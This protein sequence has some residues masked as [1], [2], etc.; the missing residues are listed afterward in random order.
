M[1][2]R[3][4]VPGGETASPAFPPGQTPYVLED[5]VGHLLRRAHQRHTALFAALFAAF[6]LTP[7]Q[8]AALAFLAAAGPMTQNLLGR[9]TAMDPATIQGVVRRL[10]GRGLVIRTSDPRDRRHVKLAL[11]QAGTAC[12]EAA[13][14]S[15][16]A[17]SEATLAPLDPEARA[18][19]LALLRRIA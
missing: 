5:Q 17:V 7:T 4:G 10:T 19:F 2:I 6:G 9:S 16:A 1:L 14:A 11:T 15:A 12:Y 18:A 3:D 13:I 8:W